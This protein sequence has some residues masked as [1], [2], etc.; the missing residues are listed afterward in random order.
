M[1]MIVTIRPCLLFGAPAEEL[2]EVA[3]AHVEL[4]ELALCAL[5]ADKQTVAFEEKQDLEEW[6][7]L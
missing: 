3:G 7:K 4:D 5:V 1:I 2:V 6:G